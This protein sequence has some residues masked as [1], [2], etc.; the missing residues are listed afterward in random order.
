MQD[1]QLEELDRRVRELEQRL[2]LQLDESQHKNNRTLFLDEV[3]ERLGE[4]DL[5]D[6]AY[7]LSVDY[8]N[9]PAKT[10]RGK[11]REMMKLFESQ[12]RLNEFVDW[13]QR[14]VPTVEWPII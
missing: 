3:N 6:A 7:E 14:R 12:K 8:D 9:L 10:K 4:E 11:A 5:R 2:L 1:E 13:L